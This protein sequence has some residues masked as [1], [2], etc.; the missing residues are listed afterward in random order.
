M[1]RIFGLDQENL[2][3]ENISLTEAYVLRYVLVNLGFI[4]NH[5]FRCSDREKEKLLKD[6]SFLH[7]SKRTLDQ[8]LRNIREQKQRYQF[9]ILKLTDTNKDIDVFGYPTTILDEYDLDLKD[10]LIIHYIN[11]I[12]YSNTMFHIRI[13]QKT[14]TYLTLSRLLRDYPI[15]KLGQS[16]L[17]RRVN[18]LMKKGLIDRKSIYDKFTNTRKNYYRLNISKLYEKKEKTTMTSV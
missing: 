17:K 5:H 1:K 9:G 12:S 6:L 14:Y 11:E 8:Y 7:L 3:S 2:L 13:N 4:H 18:I 15:L 10:M 16:G